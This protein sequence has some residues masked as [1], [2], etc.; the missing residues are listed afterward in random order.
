MLA[1]P[2]NVPVPEPMSAFTPADPD[3][4]ERIRDSFA[5]QRIM[6]LIGA[7]LVEVAPGRCRIRLPFRDDLTQQNGFFHAG[8]TSTIADSAGG[9]AGYTL[10]PA[11]SDVLTVEFKINLLR[12]AAGAMLLAEG[13]V[14][15]AGRNLTFTEVSVDAGDG[16]AM[17]V[18]ASM[19][20]T[21]ACVSRTRSEP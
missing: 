5:R 17:K 2:A 20:Q 11:Q 14:V 16:T 7:E 6:A 10:M 9:Y 13:R 1:S 4:A 8:V 19:S 15:R 18:C 3:F 12:P 21:L